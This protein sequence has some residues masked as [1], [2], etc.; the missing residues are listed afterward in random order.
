MN[1]KRLIL[2]FIAKFFDPLGWASPVII[3]SKII[4]QEL[5]LKKYDWDTPLAAELL[6][7]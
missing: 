3:I 4:I 6:D 1:S 5:W 2:S 7:P